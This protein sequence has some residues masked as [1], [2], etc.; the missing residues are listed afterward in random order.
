M[1]VDIDIDAVRDRGN[2]SDP[3]VRRL[4]AWAYSHVEIMRFVGL[5]RL[6]EMA[7]SKEPQAWR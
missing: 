2:A 1:T 6:A 5:R 4:L 3:Q 7:S